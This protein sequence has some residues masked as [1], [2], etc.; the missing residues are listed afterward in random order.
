MKQGYLRQNIRQMRL[1]LGAGSFSRAL[2]GFRFNQAHELHNSNAQGRGQF[3]NRLDACAIPAKF[4][5]RDVVAVQLSIEG[6]HLLRQACPPPQLPQHHS[7]C[8]LCFQY[9]AQ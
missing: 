3:E 8:L 5:K 2:L 7:E 1:L 4:K 9:L 6:K